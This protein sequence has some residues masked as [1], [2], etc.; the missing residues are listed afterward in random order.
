MTSRRRFGAM[1]TLILHYMP[2][3]LGY[4][5]K[6]M[7][8]FML[9]NKDFLTWFLIGW[10]L[11]CYLIR[12]QIWK[13]LLINMNFNIKISVFQV[14]KWYG[15]LRHLSHKGWIIQ[16]Q[17]DKAWQNLVDIS[18]DIVYRRNTPSLRSTLLSI[19]CTHDFVLVLFWSLGSGQMTTIFKTTHRM[20]FLNSISPLTKWSP[21]RRRY[22]QMRFLE[23]KVLYFVR[24]SIEFVPTGSVVNNSAL[25]EIMACRLFGAKPV[26]EP[27]LTRPTDAYMRHYG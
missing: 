23:W 25:V 13:F 9:V 18:L 14:P 27:M 4:W 17:K 1:M 11:C 5:V 3:G 16:L 10:W 12:S 6:S 21:F 2:V 7:L 15:W 26:S 8:T 22:F 24:I 20:H 19:E